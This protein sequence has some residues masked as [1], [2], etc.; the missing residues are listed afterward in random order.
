MFS[1]V[2]LEMHKYCIY[3][4]V[5]ETVGAMSKRTLSS[6][7]ERQISLSFNF[8]FI[9]WCLMY[10]N[11][12]CIWEL[13]VA[14]WWLSAMIWVSYGLSMDQ[15]TVTCRPREMPLHSTLVRYFSSF[16]GLLELLWWWWRFI[17]TILF[18]P[19][20]FCFSPAETS[21]AVMFS[22]MVNLRFQL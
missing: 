17:T 21:M 5:V 14:S 18:P 20:G 22:E 6:E 9:Y 4:E 15:W 10:L 19:A 2:E 3:F 11:R 1:I 13:V 12:F 16:F 7:R 8:F